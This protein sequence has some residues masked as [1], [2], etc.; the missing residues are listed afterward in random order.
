MGY[1]ALRTADATLHGARCECAVRGMY[2]ARFA[3]G[4]AGVLLGLELAFDMQTFVEAVEFAVSLSPLGP[5]PNQLYDSTFDD[6]PE[7]KVVTT[8]SRP[9]VISNVNQ[10]WM[11]LCKFDDKDGVIGRTLGCI[12]GELTDASTVNAIHSSVAAGRAHDATLINY[13]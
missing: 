9:F 8:A 2:C 10:A 11:D 7:A 3:P 5:A 12:Q 13:K 4:D 1:W 6:D